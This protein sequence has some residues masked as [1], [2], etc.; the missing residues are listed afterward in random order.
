MISTST[1]LDTL[2]EYLQVETV[3]LTGVASNICVLFTA[4]DAYMRDLKLIVPADCVA[5]NTREDNE[6]AIRQMAHVLK[7]RVDDGEALVCDG[8][9]LNCG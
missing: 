4:N 8:N 1:T 9:L 5:A 7:A 2:L 3:V 6:Y